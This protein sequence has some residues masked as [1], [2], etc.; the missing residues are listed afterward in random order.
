[1][2]ESHPCTHTWVV[3]VTHISESC[4]T[5]GDDVL[6]QHTATRYTALH[7]KHTAHTL[8]QN[9]PQQHLHGCEDDVLGFQRWW[10]PVTHCNAREHI[11]LQH[12]ATHCNS[13]LQTSTYYTATHCK[14][15]SEHTVTHYTTTRASQYTA[16]HCKH[17]ANTLTQ[18]G[19]QQHLHGEGRYQPLVGS[20]QHHLESPAVLAS[21]P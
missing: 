5:C 15:V 19:P 3:N 9:G 13:L 11:T 18:N 14:R 4:H 16:T 10:I 7:C 6:V 17:T 12:T 21:L 20:V 8:S 1:M 2:S